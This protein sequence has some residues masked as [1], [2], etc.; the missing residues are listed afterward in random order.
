M[1]S[2][3]I[4]Y[5][6]AIEQQRHDTTTEDESKRHNLEMEKLQQASIDLE[7]DRLNYQNT[8]ESERNRIQE[9]Y[10]NKYIEYQYASLETKS[11]L[12]A[13]LNAITERKNE[14]QNN[15]NMMM[16]DI[17]AAKNAIDRDVQKEN[18]RHNSVLEDKGTWYE[19]KR[20]E[21]EKYSTDM[22][23]TVRSAQVAANK[24]NT[25]FNFEFQ[26]R[27][28]LQDWANAQANRQQEM[29]IWNSKASF[30]QAELLSNN[31]LGGMKSGFQIFKPFDWR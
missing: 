18:A 8:W 30:M 14:L 21:L 7:Q 3:Q 16:A 13:E 20:A 12:E 28:L 6:T 4:S 27:K 9:E 24:M 31:L 26:N 10:N 11:A 5:A 19:Q 17:A 2:N 1:T 15:Y 25:M 29:E 22:D 23:Y